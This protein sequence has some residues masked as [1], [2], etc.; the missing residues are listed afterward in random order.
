MSLCVKKGLDVIISLGSESDAE[1]V[2]SRMLS[3]SLHREIKVIVLNFDDFDKPIDMSCYAE[4]VLARIDE[5]SRITI[6]TH[7]S[8]RGSTVQFD[9]M[10]EQEVPLGLRIHHFSRL[11]DYIASRVPNGLFAHP[12]K[13][14]T[15]SL[16][17]CYAGCGLEKSLAAKIQKHFFACHGIY[18]NL[19]ARTE[20]VFIGNPH[21]TMGTAE[22]AAHYA[23]Q[24]IQE[25][26]YKVPASDRRPFY[27]ATPDVQASHHQ[28]PKSKVFFYW[29]AKGNQRMCNAY[30]Y[31]KMVLQGQE[32]AL[33]N[34]D[35]KTKCI[36]SFVPD[37]EKSVYK[38]HEAMVDERLR[39]MRALFNSVGTFFESYNFNKKYTDLVNGIKRYYLYQ[40]KYELETAHVEN[41]IVA[42]EVFLKKSI[43]LRAFDKD[44]LEMQEIIRLARKI[45]GDSFYEGIQRA[46]KGGV[47]SFPKASEFIQACRNKRGEFSC[48]LKTFFDEFSD[49]SF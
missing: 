1:L 30:E 26:F 12:G 11:V 20:L 8:V 17:S 6:I 36:Y 33:E 32:M 49:L 13:A 39:C 27:C 48:C 34:G 19:T 41:V 9:L 45:P 25:R 21:Y 5:F 28:R 16:R 46:L 37:T 4:Q 38:S 42:I 7:S 31:K 35:L 44:S 10:Q 29:D 3:K 40:L 24:K 15:L 43:E 47:A 22:Y 2:R 18:C 14:L 23:Y